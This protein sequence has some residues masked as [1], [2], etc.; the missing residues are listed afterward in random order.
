MADCTQQ[1]PCPFEGRACASCGFN[2]KVVKLRRMILAERG[3]Q[4]DEKAETRR[5]IL[6]GR[7]RG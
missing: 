7:N 2:W 6:H 3:L 1:L 4:R 5:L